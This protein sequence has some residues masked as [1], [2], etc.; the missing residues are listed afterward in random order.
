MIPEIAGFLASHGVG[1]IQMECPEFSLYGNPRPPKSKDDYDTPRFK[2]K[3][4]DIAQRTLNAL[5]TGKHGQPPGME[6]VAVLGFE[7][8]PS[9]GVERTS[10]TIEGSMS[11]S[12]G[13]GHLMDALER[14]MELR[15][16]NTPYIGVSLRD[17]DIRRALDKLENIFQKME[18]PNRY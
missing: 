2:A 15:G 7:N 4:R 17:D 11:P 6:P 16:F 9:C 5:G 12:P 8:S 1:V 3:C 10:K 13:R 18:C 14:E